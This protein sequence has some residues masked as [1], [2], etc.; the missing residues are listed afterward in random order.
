MIGEVSDRA[1]PMLGPAYEEVRPML[2]VTTRGIRREE[3][4]EFWRS[5]LTNLYFALDSASP[6]PAQA[7]YDSRM[8]RLSFGGLIVDRVCAEP[9]RVDRTARLA[10]TSPSDTLQVAVLRRGRTCFAQDGRVATLSKP[11]DFT[12]IDTARAYRAEFH[13]PAEQLH[14]QMPRALLGPAL[15]TLSSLTAV[16]VSGRSGLAAVAASTLVALLRQPEDRDDALANAATRNVIDLTTGALLDLVGDVRAPD[17]PRA[18]VLA[19]AQQHMLGRIHEAELTPRAVAAAI[20]VSERYLFAVFRDAGTTPA[21]WL[22]EARLERARR[23]LVADPHR[24]VHEVGAAVGLPRASHFSR[25]FRERYGLS[26]STHRERSV[27][28]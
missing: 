10:R 11:G 13:T 12:V 25:L 3:Q 2:T 5:T 27:T 24:S 7:G 8:T 22:R 20:P 23:L 26:P 16:T 9:N 1:S 21:A 17:E 18:V 15:R 14:V 28:G 4:Q 19:R 6:A